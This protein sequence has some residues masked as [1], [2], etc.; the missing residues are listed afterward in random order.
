[1]LGREHCK[2]MGWLRHRRALSISHRMDHRNDLHIFRKNRWIRHARIYVYSQQQQN[3][4]KNTIHKQTSIEV[5]SQNFD[6]TIIGPLSMEKRRRCIEAQLTPYDVAEV[7]AG[8][9]YCKRIYICLRG[10]GIVSTR[11]NSDGW[12]IIVYS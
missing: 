3:N 6:L 9:I 7:F 1:M 11:L 8:R 5:N 12:P 10:D 4:N 2:Q